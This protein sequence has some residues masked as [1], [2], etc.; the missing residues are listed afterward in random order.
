MT[1]SW[2][3]PLLLGVL[4]SSTYSLQAA[5]LTRTWNFR[6]YLDGKEIGTHRFEL[7]QDDQ[8]R[9][10]KSIATYDVKMLFINAY[11]YR[12][13]AVE[14][15]DGDCLTEL[16]AH[17]DDNGSMSQVTL[18]R[19]GALTLVNTETTA[20]Q[21]PSC[22]M[23]FAYWNPSMLKQSQLLNPQS[24]DYEAVTI[25][26]VGEESI[27]AGSDEIVAQRYSLRSAKLSIDL[28]YSRQGDWLAL[29]SLTR[30]G[31]RLT[32]RLAR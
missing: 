6:V 23:S 12:H 18:A 28:W 31:H 17:T 25:N 10:I 27:T 8:A 4:L 24:G 19:E 13:E 30:D 16:K 15:W 32:Y 7:H 14:Q 1:S 29:E 20:S 5:E 26:S 2:R 11:R 22:V 3:K 9:R 21:L